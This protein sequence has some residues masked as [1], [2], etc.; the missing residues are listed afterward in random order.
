MYHVSKLSLKDS[1]SNWVMP[2]KHSNVSVKNY[3]YGN[4]MIDDAADRFGELLQYMLL[5]EDSG[6]VLVMVK[7]LYYI[8]NHV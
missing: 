2:L 6:C 4:G 1:S 8:E 5:C 7:R 3:S